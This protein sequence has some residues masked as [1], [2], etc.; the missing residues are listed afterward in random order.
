MF[1]KIILTIL[2][3]ILFMLNEGQSK[4][5]IFFLHLDSF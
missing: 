2:I 5:V 4:I 3:Y 1:K